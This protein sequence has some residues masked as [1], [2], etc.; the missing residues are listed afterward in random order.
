MESHDMFRRRRSIRQY[1]GERLPRPFYEEI[2]K[3]AMAAPS[4]VG[5]DPWRFWVLG[6]RLAEFV[7]HL[8]NGEV[9]QRA[10][11]GIL[12]CGDLTAAHSGAES[13]L[14][15]DCSAAIENMLLFISAADLGGCWMGVHPRQERI[16]GIR[17]I[18]DLPAV[19]VPVAVVAFGYP[20]EAKAPRTRYTDEY[21]TWM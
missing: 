13:F 6:E 3:A 5:R 18:L 1:T 15:Q 2:L 20:E 17:R 14:L 12:V 21:V 8:A 7:P 10:G 19:I 9:L 4:A 11:N 16:D